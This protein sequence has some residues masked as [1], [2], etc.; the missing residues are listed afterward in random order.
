MLEKKEKNVFWFDV[1]VQV[2][3][4]EFLRGLKMLQSFCSM[5]K[6]ALVHLVNMYEGIANSHPDIP[7]IGAEISRLVERVTFK[8]AGKDISSMSEEIGNVFGSTFYP[9]R[10]THLIGPQELKRKYQSSMFV[11]SLQQTEEGRKK[12]KNSGG[13]GKRNFFFLNME[14]R[15]EC[16]LD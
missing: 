16:V 13:E 7:H 11:V 15:L 2:A 10:K 5:N 4:T 3:I 1:L 9:Q 6:L 12:E 14:N 8:D